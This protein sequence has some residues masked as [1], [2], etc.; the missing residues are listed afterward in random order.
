[1]ISYTVTIYEESDFR[2][3]E[4]E[5]TDARAVEILESLT[6][7]WFPYSTPEQCV[8]CKQSDIDN[9][10]ICIAIERAISSLRR[11]EQKEHYDEVKNYPPYLDYPKPYKAKTN[12]DRIRAMSDEEL[13]AFLDKCEAR[14]NDDSSI[15][16][17]AYG[18]QMDMLKWLR[19]PA[20]EDDHA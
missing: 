11:K 4:N 5:M 20:E 9:Y 3:V 16:I 13:A 14:G 10:E 7:C 6:R 19:Q 8:D 12:A 1:M 17:N 2:K 15:A 18:E